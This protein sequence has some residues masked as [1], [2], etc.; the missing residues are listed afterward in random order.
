MVDHL[1]MVFTVDEHKGR[2]RPEIVNS[3][4]KQEV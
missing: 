4:E 1:K 2:G 3:I